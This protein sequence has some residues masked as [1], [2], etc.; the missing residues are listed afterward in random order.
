[1][2]RQLHERGPHRDMMLLCSVLDVPNS[3]P[4][5]L[6]PL[7]SAFWRD[8]GMQPCSNPDNHAIT[9][10]SRVAPSGGRASSCTHAMACSRGSPLPHHH[11]ALVRATCSCM[12]SWSSANETMVLS[13]SMNCSTQSEG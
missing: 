9:I 12:R 4:P 2:H 3:K 7:D 10:L 1:M 6:G 5:H 8:G 13:M 11:T